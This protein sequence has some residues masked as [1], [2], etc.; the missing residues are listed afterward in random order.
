MFP[1]HICQQL[2]CLL[3]LNSLVS[4]ILKHNN[5]SS[6]CGTAGREISWE[7]WDAGL[8][9]SLAQWVEDLASPQLWLRLQL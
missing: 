4:S 1:F 8:I 9:P 7:P 5:G 6:L 2:A 3:C